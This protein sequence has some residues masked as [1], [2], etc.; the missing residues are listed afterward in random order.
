MSPSLEQALLIDPSVYIQLFGF[1]FASF[2]LLTECF[3]DGND[4]QFFH[5]VTGKIRTQQSGTMQARTDPSWFEQIR[6]GL[7][8]FV[9]QAA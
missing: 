8:F 6:E 7:P 2:V 1:L 9:L 4:Q 5:A 3:A